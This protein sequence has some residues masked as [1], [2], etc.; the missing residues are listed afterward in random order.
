MMKQTESE[1]RI[2]ER[3]ILKIMDD[4][5]IKLMVNRF[6]KRKTLF[7]NRWNISYRING[8][9]IEVRLPSSNSSSYIYIND[10]VIHVY[11]AG[12]YEVLKSFGYQNDFKEIQ[13]CWRLR[14]DK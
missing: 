12:L 9:Y 7:G 10:K 11:D 3:A 5:L 2:K 4:S 14:D 13:K 8:G 1:R 6:G